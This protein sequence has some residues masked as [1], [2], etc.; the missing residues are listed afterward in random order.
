MVYFSL[1]LPNTEN[2]EPQNHTNKT[3]NPRRYDWKTKETVTGVI[4]KVENKL[5]KGVYT[6]LC[7]INKFSLGWR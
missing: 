5:I 3:P 2:R 4:V 1:W 7:H 6:C